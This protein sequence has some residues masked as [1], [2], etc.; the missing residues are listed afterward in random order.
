M[1]RDL[2]QAPNLDHLKKQAKALL[3]KLRERRPDATLNDAQHAVAREYGFPSWP[4]MKTHVEASSAGN[5]GANGG[6]TA[7]PAGSPSPGGLFD[8]FTDAAKR[9]LFFSRFEA[10][11]LGRLII[12]PEHVLLG[13]VR[14]AAGSGA[15]VLRDAGVALDDARAVIE[16]A[17]APRD[18]IVE[19]VQIPFN[20]ATKALFPAAAEEAD[21]LGHS[22]IATVHIVLALLRDAGISSSYLRG[23]G[24]TL[25]S[26]RS[27]ASTGGAA[28]EDD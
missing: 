9:T 6:G 28:G 11:S 27:A 8:R 2:P 15:V 20:P 1:S 7:P 18:T 22:K 23:K 4:K 14:G 19:P 12:G 26:V 17:N 10:S 21:R 16:A 24:M 25:D 13:V 5:R 3:R